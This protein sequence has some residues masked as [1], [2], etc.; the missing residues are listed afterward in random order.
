MRY[1]TNDF[2]TSRERSTTQS[3]QKV[4]Q[5]RTTWKNA[6][7]KSHLHT[8]TPSPTTTSTNLLIRSPVENF[9]LTR[10]L[11]LLPFPKNPTFL[12]FAAT[13]YIPHRTTYLP[14]FLPRFYVQTLYIH[15][16]NAWF[17][18]SVCNSIFFPSSSHPLINS[19]SKVQWVDRRANIMHKREFLVEGVRRQR[20]HIESHSCIFLWLVLLDFFFRR[21]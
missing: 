13:P 21:V 10:K 4:T 5:C 12:P 8:H 19:T 7:N 2:A 16:H 15:T 11:E 9:Q 18:N 17:N 1:F 6:E 14:F 3:L 20:V